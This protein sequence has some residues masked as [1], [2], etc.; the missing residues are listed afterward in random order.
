MKIFHGDSLEILKALEGAADC[1]VTD[2]PYQLTSGGNTGEMS[3]S[4]DPQSYD[5]GGTP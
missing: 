2:P 5:G 3:W 1:I 4:F